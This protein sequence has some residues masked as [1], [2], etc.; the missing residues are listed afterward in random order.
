MLITLIFTSRAAFWAF[1]ITCSWTLWECFTGLGT[2]R[3]E[4]SRFPLANERCLLRT[5]LRGRFLGAHRARAALLKRMAGAWRIYFF[6][7]NIKNPFIKGH[8]S[9]FITSKCTGSK[10]KPPFALLA[11]YLSLDRK[12][13]YQICRLHLVYFLPLSLFQMSSI[14]KPIWTCR[15]NL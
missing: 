6:S 15:V 1:W 3:I 12:K 13:K 4:R 2:A 14:D 5:V 9:Y 10:S 7:T 8:V 11:C